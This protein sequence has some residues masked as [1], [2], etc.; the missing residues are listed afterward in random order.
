MKILIVRTYPSIMNPEGYNIQEIGMAK[1]LVRQGVTCDVVFYNGK[2]K[3]EIKTIDVKCTDEVKKIN[4]YM[5]HGFGILKN[6]FFPGL[7]KLTK[8]YDVIQVHEYDQ[9]TSW[10]YYTGRKQKVVMYHGP[11]YH[12]FNKGYNLKC[13]VFDNTFLKLTNNKDTLCFTKSKAAA[14]FLSRKGFRNTVPIGVGLDTENFG[15][16]DEEMCDELKSAFC[17]GKANAVYVG[18]IEPRRNSLFLADVMAKTTEINYIVVGDG[19]KE[20]VS[21]FTAKLGDNVRYITKLSQSQLKLLYRKADFMV[22]PSNYDIFGM[23]L[24]EAM[25]F[26]LPVISSKNGGSDMLITN[27]EDGVVL[28]EF[29]IKQWVD[30]IRKMAREQAKDMHEKLIQKDH[31]VYTWDGIAKRYLDMLK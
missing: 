29:D 7:K 11:Y 3:D 10:L 26:D 24:L 12:E 21:E 28:N 15:Q 9:I 13:K 16:I 5:L 27:G 30:A 19:E 4:V 6:G 31:S 8:R 18:K 14:E 22:F 1:A 20:Y 17:A 25:F 2:N 23:V